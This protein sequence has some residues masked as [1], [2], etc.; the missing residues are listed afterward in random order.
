[1]RIRIVVASQ[2]LATFYDVQHVEDKL[3]ITTQLADPL[4]RLHDREF[5]SDRPGRMFDHGPLARWPAGPPAGGRRGATRTSRHRR[6]SGVPSEARSGHFR[7]KDS[8]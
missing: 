5:K 6:R 4:A 7:P 2:A 3:Q 8:Q 1:M